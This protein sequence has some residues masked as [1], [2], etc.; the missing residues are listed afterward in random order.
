M[1]DNLL[2][3]SQGWFLLIIREEKEDVVKDPLCQVAVQRGQGLKSS[4]LRYRS[5]V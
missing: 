1:M 2:K 4:E 5:S 3:R